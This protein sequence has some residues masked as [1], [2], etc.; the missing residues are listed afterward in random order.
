MKT[1]ITYELNNLNFPIKYFY[2]YSL[3]INIYLYF[4]R[5]L[6]KFN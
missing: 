4:Y 2:F 3:E 1:I 6:P 5:I